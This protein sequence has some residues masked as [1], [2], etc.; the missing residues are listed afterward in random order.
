MDLL[1]NILTDTL[2]FKHICNYNDFVVDTNECESSPC[3]NLATCED[4]PGY[5]ICICVKGYEGANC[6]TS[7]YSLEISHNKD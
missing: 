4:H 1:H 2:I 6:E 3:E 7:M 5:Y